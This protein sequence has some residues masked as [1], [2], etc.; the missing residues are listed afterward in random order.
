MKSEII[1]LMTRTV[2]TV[3]ATSTGQ[4]SNVLVTFPELLCLYVRKSRRTVKN[5]YWCFWYLFSSKRDFVLIGS[6]LFKPYISFFIVIPCHM[7]FRIIY[8]KFGLHFSVWSAFYSY[9]R[10]LSQ[11]SIF[12]F[13]NALNCECFYRE[14]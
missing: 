6:T 1:Y 9:L 7:G 10:V 5:M 3:R 12:N 2:K 13:S 11:G 14:C 4:S 8:W